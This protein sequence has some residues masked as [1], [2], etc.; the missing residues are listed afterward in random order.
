EPA[1][2]IGVDH[3]HVPDVGE[4]RQVRHDAREA[5]ELLAAVDAEV[6][7]IT[8]RALH[9]R[10]RNAGRPVRSLEIPVDGV[11]IEL[12]RIRAHGEAVAVPLQALDAS[13][14]LL[15]CALLPRLSYP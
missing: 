3:E 10:S 6:E 14:L 5:D 9:H 12:T 8:E 2:S 13:E 1:P 15:Q 7:R 11:D 4:R